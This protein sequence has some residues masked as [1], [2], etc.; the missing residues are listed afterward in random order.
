MSGAY[1]IYIVG[2]CAN[3]VLHYSATV[4]CNLLTVVMFCIHTLPLVYRTM[5]VAP[6]V[7]LMNAMACRVFRNTKFGNQL[8]VDPTISIPSIPLQAPS[9]NSSATLAL[10]D[11]RSRGSRGAIE[12]RNFE[13]GDV[14]DIH[15][16]YK[17]GYERADRG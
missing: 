4:G 15:S 6:N 3:S 7:M 8:W 16:S 1:I 10:G 13:N 11:N 14:I 12:R 2:R 9:A 5:F 17:N